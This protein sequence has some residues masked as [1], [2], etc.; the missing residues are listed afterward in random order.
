MV[1]VNQSCSRCTKEYSWKLQPLILGKF[2][3]GNI[4]LSFPVLIAGASISKIMLVFR[5]LC[6][7]V[8]STRTFF[9]HQKEFVFPTILHHWESYRAKLLDKLKNLKDVVWCGDGR[10]DSIGHSAKYGVYTMMSTTLLKIVHYEI[11]Q[12]SLLNTFISNYYFLKT[13]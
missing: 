13:F 11:V 3:A 7:C 2:P 9:R 5:H 10:F 12:V 6:V 4:T 8:Y 1:T